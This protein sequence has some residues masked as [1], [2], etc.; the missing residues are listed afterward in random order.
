MFRIII[1]GAGFGGLSCALSLSRFNHDVEIVVL[2]RKETFDFLPLLP[3]T[4]GRGISPHFLSCRIEPILKKEGLQF[5]KGE[6]SSID[7]FRKEICYNSEKIDT[8]TALSI[9]PE[10]VKR[11]ER[12]NFD[13]LVIASGS[14]TNFYANE[15]IKK[16]A[17]TLDSADDA[18]KILS[19]LKANSFDRFIIGGGGYT[20]IEVATNL[21]LWSLANK[22]E[23]EIII[24]E[25]ADSILGPLPQWMKEYTRKNLARLHIEVFTQSSI[26]RIDGSTVY[27]SNQK[28]FDNALV[29]WVAGVKTAKF[30]QELTAEKNTQGR[31]KVDSFLRLNENCFIVGDAAYVKYKENYLR[32]AIQF[33][34]AQGDL[35]A[36]NIIRAIKGKKPVSYKSIDLGYIIPMANNYSC[37]NVFGVNLKGKPPTLLHFIMCIYRLYGIRNKI[38]FIR[39]LVLHR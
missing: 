2:D 14:E 5:I 22:K 16:S 15:N 6:V 37:G 9:N 10:R 31:L 8:S 24:V 23:T 34:M 38:G 17:Y 4:L 28:I 11:V 21:R 7:L 32:M 13:F 19:T 36:K 39:N 18:V 35:T 20:G 27:V 12:V 3:D 29:I 33:A 26:E 30:I 25:K 1:I